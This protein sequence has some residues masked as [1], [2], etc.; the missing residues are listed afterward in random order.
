MN[1]RPKELYCPV[2]L[3]YHYWTWE[4]LVAHLERM[5]ARDTR[6]LAEAQEEALKPWRKAFQEKLRRDSEI[7][8]KLGDARR[9]FT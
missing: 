5:K 9:M 6:K 3:T 4:G 2:C 7:A 1:Y 8:R